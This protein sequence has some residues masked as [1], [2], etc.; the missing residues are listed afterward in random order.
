MSG[1]LL[2]IDVGNSSTSLGLIPLGKSNTP[3]ARW[4]VPTTRLKS[5]FFRP[6]LERWL[7]SR[8]INPSKLAGASISSVVPAV[9]PA[10]KRTLASLQ[11]PKALFI[12]STVA[13]RVQNLY[14][15]PSEVGADRLVNARAA[16]ELHKGAS[17]VVDFGTATTFDCVAKGGKYLGGVIAPGPVIS[18]EA[19]F[20]RTAK[21]PHVVLQKPARALGRNT[22]EAI[23]AGLYHGY[24]GLVLEVVL[25]LKKTMGGKAKVI[26]TGGQARWILKGLPIINIYEPDLTLKGLFYYWKDQI[27]FKPIR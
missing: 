16:M 17:I 19:L 3:T 2:V 4:A 9:D 13:S 10:L 25:Q 27:D 26:A 7:R 21:L 15:K 22:K 1:A 14:S 18:A 23:E 6:A 24:R 8:K 5:L 20:A 11:I 12:S